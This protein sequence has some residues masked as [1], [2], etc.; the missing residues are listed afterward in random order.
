MPQGIRSDKPPISIVGAAAKNR[1]AQGS[2]PL[3][4]DTLSRSA[5][6]TSTASTSKRSLNVDSTSASF[7]PLVPTA[8]STAAA[9]LDKGK[10]KAKSDVIE[11]DDESDG[12]DSIQDDSDASGPRVQTS[13]ASS[14]ARMNSGP[15]SSA[16][17]AIP[18]G[19]TQAKKTVFEG[20]T[21]Q[22]GTTIH[23]RPPSH[24]PNTSVSDD[25][26]LDSFSLSKDKPEKRVN[27]MQ[28]RGSNSTSTPNPRSKPKI[29]KDIFR[30]PLQCIVT[31]DG[32][33]IPMERELDLVVNAKGKDQCFFLSGGCK[34]AGKNTRTRGS[35]PKIGDV[36]ISPDHIA[37]ITVPQEPGHGMTFMRIDIDADA[38]ASESSDPKSPFCK[39]L[40]WQRRKASGQLAKV[41][42][43]A[44][45]HRARLLPNTFQGDSTSIG[46]RVQ[47][48]QG[49]SSGN[50]SRRLSSGMGHVR[51]SYFLENSYTERCYIQQQQSTIRVIVLRRS[52]KGHSLCKRNE[53]K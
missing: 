4:E 9:S 5:Q 16:S 8:T 26:S 45:F 17:R 20:P 3:P 6:S 27:S 50:Q 14:R 36:V 12:H 15:S 41:R 53:R 23:Q 28:S 1:Q 31:V 48:G 24:K 13:K 21:K 19:N 25:E 44:Q 32:T 7:M 38:D 22:Q 51:F 11:L 52:R 37:C 29:K 46:R 18:N 30:L 47:C 35:V 34:H 49:V 42:T 40:H 43:N 33:Y 2:R 10:G 39:C